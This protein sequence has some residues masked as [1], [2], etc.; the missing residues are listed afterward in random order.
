MTTEPLHVYKMPAGRIE[1]TIQKLDYTI[2]QLI[3]AIVKE[4]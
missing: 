2:A 3:I 4:K 1:L